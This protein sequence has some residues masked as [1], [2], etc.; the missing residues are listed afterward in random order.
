MASYGTQGFIPD[1][2]GAHFRVPSKPWYI[3]GCNKEQEA[4]QARPVTWMVS[5]P[6]ETVSVH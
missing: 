3:G 5:T 4:G 2:N 1:I 6:D